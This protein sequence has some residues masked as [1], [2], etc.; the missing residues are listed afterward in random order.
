MMATRPVRSKSCFTFTDCVAV[1]I[2]AP[3]KYARL[4]TAENAEGAEEEELIRNE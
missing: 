1:D 2:S 3:Q 4:F